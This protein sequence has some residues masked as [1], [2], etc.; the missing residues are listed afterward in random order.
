MDVHTIAYMH[1]HVH[2]HVLM[3]NGMHK[4]MCMQSGFCCVKAAVLS[5]TRVQFVTAV[6]STVTN[7]TRVVT[8]FS[9]RIPAAQATRDRATAPMYRGINTTPCVGAA[10]G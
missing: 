10:A 2:V 3:R 6:E 5:S 1:V 8:D 4:H 9:D 7:C